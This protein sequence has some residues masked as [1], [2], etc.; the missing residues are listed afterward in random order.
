VRTEIFYRQLL[1]RIQR[2]TQSKT[3]EEAY[4]FIP[5][6][7]LLTSYTRNIENMQ[8]KA[9]EILEEK[10]KREMSEQTDRAESAVVYDTENTGVGLFVINNGEV[11]KERAYRVAAISI[12]TD[13]PYS[14]V[15]LVLDAID[16]GT[17]TLE[18]EPVEK[19]ELPMEEIMLSKGK[20]ANS[21]ACQ[22]FYRNKGVFNE[23]YEVHGRFIKHELMNLTQMESK[24]RTLK[25]WV[26]DGVQS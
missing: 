15:E 19:V 4:A 1:G 26:K 20:E 13:L 10:Q 23:I 25:N 2:T 14:S 22:V 18:P 9:L 24:I 8:G 5:S 3:I 7:P 12:K 16:A 17:E 21:L 6:D 11:E